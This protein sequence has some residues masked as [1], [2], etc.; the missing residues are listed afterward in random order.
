VPTL[1]L[2]LIAAYAVFFAAIHAIVT[3]GSGG[4]RRP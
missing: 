3:R 1:V 2:A 4:P